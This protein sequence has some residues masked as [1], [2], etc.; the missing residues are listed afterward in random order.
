MADQ[1][2][3]TRTR[4]EQTA[5]DKAA[6]EAM[7]YGQREP[8]L[9]PTEFRDGFNFRTI[10]GALFV[11]IVM[12]PGTIYLGLIVGRSLGPAAEWTTIILFTE[13]ARRSFMPLARQEIYVIYYMASSL[14][15]VA[16]TLA[17]GGG[18]FSSLIW[19]QYV[20]QSPAAQQFGIARDVPAWYAPP[21]GSPAL[22]ERTFFH[23]DWLLPIAV[24]VVT[25]VLA[26]F[27]W[28]G[29]GYYLFRATSDVERLPFPLA[30]VIAQGATALAEV[31][32]EEESWRWPVF[33]VG[34]VIGLSYGFLYIAL[35]VV[36][37]AFLTRPLMLLPIPFVDFTQNVETVLPTA[38][39]ALGTDLGLVLTGFILPYPVVI[40]QFIAA[41]LGNFV[42][43]PTLYNMNP[44][45]FPTWQRGMDM[46]RTEMATSFDLWMSVGMGVAGAIALIGIYTVIASIM[47]IG[48]AHV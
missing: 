28:I 1:E 29:L 14:A 18:A 11:G 37:G 16:G 20:R 15:Y 17:L 34:S 7:W 44:D 39:V 22:T 38:R 27:Q 26:R 41:M 21:L 6:L 12:M 8:E 32:R 46:I 4:T 24:L 45:R 42:I 30:P 36:S 47:Q 9:E 33:S 43:S 35:P 23:H 48:R 13:V 31:S 40:G 2:T 10:L 25:Q 19:A 3:R 5:E